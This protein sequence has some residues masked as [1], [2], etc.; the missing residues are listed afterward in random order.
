MTKQESII[1]NDK[2]STFRVE[3]NLLLPYM[4]NHISKFINSLFLRLIPLLGR[5]AFESRSRFN[6]RFQLLMAYIQHALWIRYFTLYFLIFC[7]Y[8]LQGLWLKV[9]L[10]M[11]V[12]HLV[13]NE[14]FV[15]FFKE[16]QVLAV[17]FGFFLGKSRWG[18]VLLEHCSSK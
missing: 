5:T 17:E 6:R 8:K 15:V 4:R 9:F 3:A 16:R 13:I 7:L 12:F 18:C 2:N 11:V 1:R 10:R 14:V